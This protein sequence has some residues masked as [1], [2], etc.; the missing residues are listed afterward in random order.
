LC[1]AEPER[2]ARLMVD[3][4]FAASYDYSLQAMGDVPYARWRE[5]ASEETV[6][7]YALRLHE[8]GLIRSS[9]KKIVADGTDWRF[10]NQ[11]KRE[12]KT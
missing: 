5:F 3:G 8:A 11:L 2:V 1:V 7:F 12:L 10:L 9:P 6:C 4:G